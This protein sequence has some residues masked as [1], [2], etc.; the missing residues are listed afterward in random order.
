MQDAVSSVLYARQHI[1]DQRLHYLF[2][3]IRD[4]ICVEWSLV[5]LD[6]LPESHLR[7]DLGFSFDGLVE[8]AMAMEEAFNIAISDERLQRVETVRDLVMLADR[9]A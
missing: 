3:Q 1:H 2:L 7:D 9:Q 4:I 8:V 5:A 6:V